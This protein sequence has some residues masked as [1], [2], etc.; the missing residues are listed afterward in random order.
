MLMNKSQTDGE[1]TLLVCGVSAAS[2]FYLFIEAD[3]TELVMV[4]Y[5]QGSLCLCVCVRD[6]IFSLPVLQFGVRSVVALQC[7][8]ERL[9]FC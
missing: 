2:H 7:I 4:W 1:K 8:V 9:S 3:K 6:L 5:P